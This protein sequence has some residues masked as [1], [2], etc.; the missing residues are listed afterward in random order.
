MPR[1]VQG[2]GRDDGDLVLRSPTCLAARE[3]SA[4]VGIIHLNLSPQQV[5][6]LPLSHGA[7]DLVVQQPGCVVFHP[8]VAAELHSAIC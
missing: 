2:N 1:L 3:F 6:L 4:E 7:Q 8:Q 5:C